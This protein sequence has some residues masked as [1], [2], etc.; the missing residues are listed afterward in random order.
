MLCKAHS[1][2]PHSSTP[3]PLNR[4]FLFHFPTN[5]QMGITFATRTS[6]SAARANDAAAGKCF[7]DKS[8]RK[9]FCSATMLPTTHLSPTLGSRSPGILY[10]FFLWL[11]LFTSQHRIS[12]CA[13]WD[14]LQ[15]RLAC[16]L[17][18][19]LF[20]A[21]C[22]QFMICLVFGADN[23]HANIL[24]PLCQLSLYVPSLP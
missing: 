1:I 6:A 13:L 18:L 14:A 23:V 24:I 19:L 15:R 11:L 4:I 17:P 9:R 5:K 8:R 12:V 2:Y 3:P 20:S 21:L 7:D 16:V 22:S 10:L